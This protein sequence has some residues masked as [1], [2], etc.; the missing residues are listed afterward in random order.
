MPC[1]ICY[2]AFTSP[3]SLPCGHV[4]CTSC[5][6]NTVD[7]IKSCSVQHWCPTCRVPYSVVTLDPALIPPYLRPHIQPAIRPI[8]FDD[9]AS[10]PASAAAAATTEAATTEVPS[11]LPEVPSPLSAGTSSPPPLAPHPPSALGRALAEADALR[12]S[13]Q[14]WRR[15][16]E[17]HAAAN[18]GLLGF[19]RATKDAAVRLRVERDD[20]R[21]RCEALGRRVVELS[22]SQ[23]LAAQSDLNNK[24]RAKPVLPAFVRQH[25]TD[26]TPCEHELG[27]PLKRRRATA[28]DVSAAEAEA[29]CRS[30]DVDHDVPP[31]AGLPISDVRTCSQ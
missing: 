9:T 27:P 30:M 16:A 18:A 2:E 15:R 26:P 3:I 25:K 4:F 20:A 14:T 13:C 1:S 24:S 12:L 21:R 7:A 8:F 10:P 19:A 17:V 5:I 23:L 28:D 6:R 31:A 29:R 22:T 11:P